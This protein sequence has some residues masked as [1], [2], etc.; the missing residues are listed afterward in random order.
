MKADAYELRGKCKEMAEAAVLSDPTLTLVR[1]HYYC[2]TWGKQQHWWTIRSDGSVFDPTAAQFPSL[3]MGEYEP[4][5]GMCACAECGTEIPEA[6]V[7]YAE[8]RFVF[9]SYTC[10]GRFVG[11]F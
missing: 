9:C 8:S 7:Q 1:G 3:G 2:P 4:F 11:A 5:N 6:E 10:H